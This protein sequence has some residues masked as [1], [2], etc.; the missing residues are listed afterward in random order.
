MIDLTA[1]KDFLVLCQVRS[2]SKASERCHVSISG[3][4]RRIQS[5]EHWLGAPVFDRHKT[6]LEMTDAGHRL[7]AVAT[8]VV[9]ALEGVR[10]SV[11]ENAEDRQR[12]VRFAAPHVMSA[13]F[14]PDWIPRL[15]NEFRQAKFSVDSDN[16]PECMGM[17]A[18]GDADFVV[19]LIDDADTVADRI[20]LD[21]GARTHRHL[22]LGTERLIPVTAPNAA[23]QPLF[24][25]SKR[26]HALSFLGYA[27]ECHL[28]W[29]LHPRLD[30]WPHLDLQSSHSSSL[31]D[32][33]RMMALSQ[34]GMAWLPE[35]LVRHDLASK[36]LM[37][38]GDSSFDIPL[39]ITLIRQ[40]VSL[41]NQAEKLWHYLEAL[42]EQAEQPP[43]R[44]DEDIDVAVGEI[45]T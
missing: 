12:R 7:Q 36:K 6:A 32:G 14:F 26:G 42:C 31:T 40:D 15:H 9:Y 37:R 41:G 45:S 20:G 17:L 22:T 25:L 2:F 23:G 16:L 44:L 24:D 39:R 35:T 33:L 11:R 4:S 30:A 1:L 8:E 34:L 38:A 43:D 21:R 19:A 5:L 3:L 27:D 10:K 18:E 13:V 29:S 28:G